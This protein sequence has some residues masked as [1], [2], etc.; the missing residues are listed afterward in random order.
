M[1]IRKYIFLLFVISIFTVILTYKYSEKSN[2][3]KPDHFLHNE[4]A[5][6][7]EFYSECM[8]K[9]DN[10]I[11]LKILNESHFEI[12]HMKKD[13]D[14]IL[15]SYI[16]KKFQKLA[17]NKFGWLYRGAKQKIVSFSLYGKDP[18][19]SSKL[20]NLTR[21]IKKYYP[22]WLIRVYHDETILDSL[23]CKIE[24]QID[25]NNNL[26]DN[27]DFCNIEKL[28]ASLVNDETWQVSIHKMMWRWLPIGDS[29][30]DVFVSRDTDSLILQRE[31][32][33]VQIWM[34][35]NKTGHIMRGRDLFFLFS[36]KT[37]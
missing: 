8:C 23:K 33:S 25:E 2:L 28:P 26:I 14:K 6:Q 21:L 27:S 1:F 4:P 15:K 12:I 31:I 9:Q 13:S 32:D 7:S 24:C 20:M 37:L 22:D 35:S 16:L 5:N 18:F 11:I 34:N 29:F 3:S 10:K 17:C 19:Y 36:F 30:V